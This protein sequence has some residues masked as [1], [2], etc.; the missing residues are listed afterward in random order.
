MI[1]E[2]KSSKF[3]IA[4]VFRDLKLQDAKWV[5]DGIE[6]M[7]EALEAIGSI[8]QMVK[9]VKV[10]QA[11]SFKVKMPAN[12]ALLEEV[13]YGRYTSTKTKDNPPKL[14]DFTEVMAYDGRG[15]HPSLIPQYNTRKS[16]HLTHD[17]TFFIK[18]GMINVSFEQ[19]W[20]ALEY[21]AFAVDEDGYPMV[22][23][24]YSYSQAL[25]W[26]IVMK[27]MEG[28]M[29]HPAG[30]QQINWAV[31]EDR[32]QYYCGQ[33]RNQSKMPDAS[34]YRQFMKSWVKLVPDYTEVDL[35]TLGIDYESPE[36]LAGMAYTPIKDE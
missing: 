32:W 27:M 18:N 34:K 14:E 12:L 24:H 11:S 3:V 4:K 26:Y 30:K 36:K 16:A 8:A 28:G 25:Y 29:E 2:F 10:A 22:P 13:R 7:G 21:Q 6:W 31:A 33:A 23:D 1:Y 5:S 9:E 17:E 20:V 19:D 15:T 35:R